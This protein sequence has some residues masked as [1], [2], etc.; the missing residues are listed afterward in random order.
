MTDRELLD[1]VRRR[2]ASG[3]SP[4]SIARA[5]GV[6]PAVIAP[7]ARHLAA[8]ASATSAAEPE[9]VGCWV[10]PGWSRDLLVERR[11]GWEDVDLGPDGPAGVALA[12]VGR[13]A[14]QDRVSVCGYLV[15]TFCLGVKNVIGPEEM[16]SRDLPSFVRM[17]FAAFPAPPLR[18]PIDL[19]QHLVLGAIAFAAHLGFEAH[20]EFA[21]AR[22]HLGELAEPCAITFGQRGRPLY[23][24]GPYDNPAEILDKL[25]AAIGG[26]GFTAAAA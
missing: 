25:R 21:A 5:L 23:V 9:L 15:D 12:L 20:P 24:A 1:E 11:G 7:L 22:Q 14:R 10:S 2:R 26:D 16:R 6:R 3:A 18:V 8:E 17:Y 19:G 4:K 13:S